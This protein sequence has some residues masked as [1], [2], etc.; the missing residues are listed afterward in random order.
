MDKI[1]DFANDV[2]SLSKEQINKLGTAIID[3][4]P[5]ISPYYASV[6]ETLSEDEEID[7]F[8][9]ILANT[10]TEQL[11]DVLKDISKE[12]RELVCNLIK[13]A[14]EKYKKME[15]RKEEEGKQA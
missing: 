14:K 1:S 3:T 9:A 13:E 6:D 5:K 15:E 7:L 11:Y 10:N 12:K 4:L 8:T 2:G